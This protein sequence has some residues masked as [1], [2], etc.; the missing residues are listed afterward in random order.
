MICAQVFWTVGLPVLLQVITAQYFVWFFCLMPLIQPYTT[1][2]FRWKGAVIT[3]IWTGAQL[4]WLG[5]A[6]MLEFKGKNVFLPLW[7][8]SLVFFAANVLVLVTIIAYHRFCPLFSEGRLVPLHDK[9][10]RKEK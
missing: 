7:I 10:S 9:D 1:L 8:A 5:W 2:K 6:Y 3:T 4:H